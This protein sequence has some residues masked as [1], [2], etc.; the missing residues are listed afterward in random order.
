MVLSLIVVIIFAVMIILVLS[1]VAIMC[2]LYHKKNKAVVISKA[3]YSN[4]RATDT[5]FLLSEKSMSIPILSSANPAYDHVN[6]TSPKQQD[7]LKKTS[8]VML[9]SNPYPFTP[10]YVDID[11][12]NIKPHSTTTADDTYGDTAEGDYEVVDYKQN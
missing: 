2:C 10:E 4:R 12:L 6:V 9:S 11:E 8:Q 3:L 7:N 5:C 1:A